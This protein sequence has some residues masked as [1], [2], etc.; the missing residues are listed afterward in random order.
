MP[1]YNGYG[2]ISGISGYPQQNYYNSPMPDRF[3]QSI[4]QYQQPQPVPQPAS[5]GIIWVQGE[6]GAKA[7][8]V[9]PGN[10]VQL[11]DSE[12]PVI[13]LKSA[14]MSGMPSMRILDWTE[15]TAAHKAPL[16]IPQVDFVTREEFTALEDRLNT[17]M[18]KEYSKP[19]KAAKTKED[20]GN[21]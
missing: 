19:A 15:R 9:A 7:Y 6:E 18:A 2:N 16:D 13:Y 21:G 12:N 14:D 1:N 17:L 10:T 11:W 8:M 5:N 3:S 20:T 4:G